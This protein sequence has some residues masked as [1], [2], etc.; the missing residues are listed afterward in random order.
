M[1]SIIIFSIVVYGLSNCLV[2]AEGPFRIFEFYRYFMS[3]MP[4]NL[5]HG[6][7]CMICTPFQVGIILSLINI[8]LITDMDF[9]PMNTLSCYSAEYWYIKIILDGAFG[10]GVTW[11]IHTFQECLENNMPNAE[12]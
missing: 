6:A 12:S 2:Y 1:E 7:T 4:S 3:K 9:T 5:G 10:S 8:F 11:L